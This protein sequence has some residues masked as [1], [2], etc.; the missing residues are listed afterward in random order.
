M[1]LR[2]HGYVIQLCQ[3]LLKALPGFLDARK[4]ARRAAVEKARGEKKG[5]FSGLGGGSTLALMK[6]SGMRRKN[7][8]SALLPLLE[9]I[10][11]EDPHN[12]Q[13]NT[14]L[15]DAAL[16]SEPPMPE[17]AMF[18]LETIA[19]GSPGD[20]EQLHRFATYC[21]EQ[22]DGVNRRDPARAVEI[23]NR[24]LEI[25]PNDLAAIKGGKD[26]AA[27]QSVQQGGW[28][29]ADSYRDL[30]KDKEE[31]VSL[32]QQSR[33]VKSGEMLDRQIA[34][35]S[36]A[37]QKNPQSIDQSRRVAE[38][39]ELKEDLENALEWYRYAL[40]LSGGADPTLVR[41]VSDLQLRQIDAATESRE[42]Y[43]AAAPE[44]PEAP[45]YRAE[46]EELRTRRAEF[47]L[48][49]ARERVARNPT[50]LMAHFELGI[51]LMEAGNHQEAIGHLQRARTNP[52]VRLRAMGQLGQC[53]VAR[54][55]DDLAAKTLSDAV[56]EL[57]SMDSV[58]KD[59][60]YNL[61]SVYERMG[62]RDKALE[63]LKQ[64]YEVDYGYRDVA[65][66]VE[67]SYSQG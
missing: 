37:V 66:K 19:E 55:M 15:H 35:L 24:I 21:M 8:L 12:V 51:A 52:S 36:A 65:Q 47:V 41:K 3:E 17:L 20:T 5:F 16:K 48:S 31:A 61:A 50:D 22:E 58:K 23:Y 26:A 6:A 27:A 45:R 40:G 46:L 33:V 25:N 38:L 44:D 63:C 59:L 62:Q 42:Q 57:T 34:E 14:L 10:L 56:S 29:V 11:G 32:E 1:E 43:L 28:E 54:G 18:A 9:E 53:Y 30:I 64:I 49:E 7:D 2:N 4:L 39:Y 67:A 13:A 60:L